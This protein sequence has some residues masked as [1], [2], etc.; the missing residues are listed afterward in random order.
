MII[1]FVIVILA[2]SFWLA[3]TGA[4]NSHKAFVQMNDIA[5][6]NKRMKAAGFTKEDMKALKLKN[7]ERSKAGLPQLD[8]TGVPFENRLKK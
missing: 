4:N 8:W 5:Q 3:K 6:E 7:I 2:F 1:L